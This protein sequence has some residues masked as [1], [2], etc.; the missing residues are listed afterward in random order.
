MFLSVADSWSSSMSARLV[1]V[2]VVLFTG[3]FGSLTASAQGRP[4]APAFAAG[5]VVVRG[6][7][8]AIMPYDERSKIDLIGGRVDVKPR[9]LPDI[10]VSLFLNEHW[11]ITGQTGVVKTYITLKDTLYGDIDVGSVQSVPLAVSAQYHFTTRGRWTPY[12]GVG[13]VANWSFGE[14]PAGGYVQSFEVSVPP[15][16]LVKAGVDYQISE[17][18]FANFEA[19][20]IFLPDQTIED[21]GITARS[22]LKTVTIGAGVG[23]RF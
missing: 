20:Q 1:L 23:S 4:V 18:W 17:R 21:G 12:V 5:D 11:S 19:R 13:V 6:R 8:T 7:A 14:K 15:A 2:G 10:D 22:S 3:L 16:P 9:V